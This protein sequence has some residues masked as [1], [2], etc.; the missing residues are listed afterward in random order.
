MK[1]MHKDVDNLKI[2]FGIITDIH[3]N[4]SA[5]EAVLKDISNRDIDHIFCLGD[6]VGIGPES[7]EVL[8]KLM[9]REDISY[10]IGNHDMAVLAA[11]NQEEAPNGHQTERVH[12]QWL[13]DRIN[14]KYIEFMTKWPKQLSYSVGDKELLFTHYHL[15]DEQWFLP[16]DKQPTI[17]GLDQIY[18]ETTYQLVCFGHHH[19]V[20]NFVST[21]R[22]FFN[23]G[24]LGCNHLP[25]AKYGVVSITDDEISVESLAIPYDNKSFLQKYHELKVPDR[26]FILKIFHGGQLKE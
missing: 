6:V 3:G 17:D 16:I 21:R 22:T 15:D 18:S 12:H 19:I 26:E 7:N 4:S 11:F 23:P 1:K 2:T 14:P 5:L 10:V 9:Q 13:A 8:E 25:V 20:H 24:S